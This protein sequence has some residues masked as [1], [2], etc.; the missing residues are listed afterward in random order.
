MTEESNEKTGVIRN[1]INS[2]AEI[3]GG[4]LGGALGFLAAGPA[5]AAAGGAGGAAAAVGLKHIGHEVGERY[6]APR[7]KA[8]AGGVLAI[9]AG[10]T[11]RSDSFFTAQNSGR[12]EA[13][14]IAE[15][16]IIK[17]QKEPEEK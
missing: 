2:G 15:S 1:L 12:P 6:L 11:L 9:A 3:A 7:E 17:A 8:R 16:V 5:G 14:E 13:E 10:E 4:A